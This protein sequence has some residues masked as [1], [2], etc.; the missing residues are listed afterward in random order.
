[1]K[2]PWSLRGDVTEE[3]LDAI[4][5]AV[6]A[7]ERR[8]SG[9][10][11]VHIVHNLLPLEKPRE[12]ALRTFLRLG[13][14]RTRERNGV[15]LFVAMKKRCFEIVA[16]EAID[17]KVEAETWDAIAEI[18]AERIDRDGFAEGISD[19][20]QRIGDLL[21][22]HFPKTEGDRDELPNRPSLG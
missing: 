21:A 10:I 7:A 14:H 3:A 15:L 22:E 2:V 20:I 1:M 8:T 19:G 4:A 18:I 5:A 17:E 13:M 12:R 9:E 11:H 6:D 16:D